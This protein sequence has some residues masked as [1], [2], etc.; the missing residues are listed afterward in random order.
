MAF[1]PAAIDAGP[2]L[3]WLASVEAD[4]GVRPVAGTPSPELAGALERAGVACRSVD[5]PAPLITP[6]PAG[7]AAPVLVLDAGVTLAPGSL[8]RALALLEEDPRVASVSVPALGQLSGPAVPAPGQPAEASALSGDAGIALTHRLRDLG[9]VPGAVP[10]PVA[11]GP[12]VLLSVQ[13]LAMVGPLAPCPS[14]GLQA[15]LADWSLRGRQRGLVD[16]LDPGSWWSGPEAEPLSEEDRAWLWDRHPVTAAVA[17]PAPGAEVRLLTVA[18][19]GTAVVNQVAAP[20]QGGEASLGPGQAAHASQDASCPVELALGV[21]RAKVR[22]LAVLVDGC[23][24]G[25]IQTGVQVAILALIQAL[26]ERPDV[27]LVA[28][29]LAGPAPPYA[30]RVL[31]APKVAVVPSHDLG[32][33]GPM[34]VAHRPVQPDAAFRMERWQAAAERTVVTV[35]DLIAYRCGSYQ[36]DL[37]EWAGLRAAF[38]RVLGQADGVVTVSDDVGRQLAGEGLPVEASRQF[39]VAN[40]TDHLGAERPLRRPAGAPQGDFVVCLGTD[41]THKNRD[42]AVAAMAELGRRGWRLPLVVAGPAVPRGSSRPA[43]AA[44]AQGVEAGTAQGV[45]VVRLGEMADDER[46][47]LLAQARAV[48]YPTSA[49]GFGLVPFEAA[50]LG[51]PTVEVAFGPLAEVA[52]ALPVRAAGWRPSELAQAMEELLGD[53]DLTRAQVAAFLEAGERWTWA[54]TAER[55]TQVYREVLGRPP[56][57]AE[58]RAEAEGLRQELARERADAAVVSR[59]ASGALAQVAGLREEL[60]RERAAA[61]ALRSSRAY[62]AARLLGQARRPWARGRARHRRPE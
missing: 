23:Y 43:E 34:E 12:A 40:G 46:N 10:L 28:V 25:P 55:L 21:A 8:A 33:L 35:H 17:G 53:P 48:L 27:R 47:W 51:T 5:G 7:W 61:A 57:G 41:Y 2:A 22:G 54:A 20:A 36:P 52:P 13:A 11:R 14:G 42:L 50:R 24:L 56:R 9:P 58:L 3:T 1:L 37:G 49:E 4:L 15:A 60:A 59:E 62:R 6:G 32:S 18:M 19:S 31:G 16:V 29:A 45:E 30:T 38:A 39:V 26:A 44:A